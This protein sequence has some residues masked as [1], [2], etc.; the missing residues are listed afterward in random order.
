MIDTRN[1]DIVALYERET[2]I[3]LGRPVGRGEKA[4]CK[5]PCF[6][7]GGTDRF[8]AFLYG[9]PP[10]YHCGVNNGSGCGWHGDAIDLI[11]QLKGTDFA[12]AC[13]HLEIPLNGTPYQ[14]ALHMKPNEPRYDVAPGIEWQKRGVQLVKDA[15]NF[16]WSG[17]E[18]AGRARGYLTKRGLTEETIRR[19]K[20]GYVPGEYIEK[21]NTWGRFE[22]RSTWGLKNEVDRQG[23]EQKHVFIPRGWVIPWLV[24]IDHE[25]RYPDLWRLDIRRHPADIKAAAD[26]GQR[27]GKYHK[28][29]GSSEGLYN[30]QAIKENDPL[31]VVESPVDALI[32]QQ[33]TRECVYVATG[34]TGGARNDP[35]WRE[36]IKRA[37][38]VLCA[39]DSDEAGSR[40][41]AEYW[42]ELGAFRWLPTRH[43]INDMKLAG[44]N[45]EQWAMAGLEQAILLDMQR[46]EE[47]H[48]IA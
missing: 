15:M 46:E 7:C 33:E 47:H 35:R 43:D 13:I 45:I 22:L 42:R 40:A 28:I 27:I 41:F 30:F 44:E 19:A 48:A 39:F 12:G 3:A 8:G 23:K 25:T 16:L 11:K 17:S 26:Q 20:L 14:G 2:G 24:K 1:I 10:H 36:G 6:I 31:M 38:P 9:D 5:G 37:W 29:A 34:G 32:G 21:V 4:C 18:Q